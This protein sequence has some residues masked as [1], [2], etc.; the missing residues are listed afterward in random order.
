MILTVVSSALVVILKTKVYS[1]VTYQ[2]QDA[3]ILWR[4]PE[5]CEELALSFNDP[6]GCDEIFAQIEMFQGKCT[7]TATIAA[8]AA[9]TPQDA[10]FAS[11]LDPLPSSSQPNDFSSSSSST[12]SLRPMS[13]DYEPN[14]GGIFGSGDN[15]GLAYPY[16][17]VSQSSS[18]STNSGGGS[19][20][21]SGSG[22]GGSVDGISIGSDGFGRATELP[23]PTPENIGEVERIITDELGSLMHRNTLINTIVQEDYIGKLVVAFDKCEESGATENLYKFFSIFKTLILLNDTKILEV[24]FSQRYTTSVIGAFECK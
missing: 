24:L 2:K 14:E 7:A 5:K 22:G 11:A 18:S 20:S 21:S 17:D 19:S 13:L 23:R 16:G 10:P 3:I 8:A 1:N 6:R 15:S 12:P 4:E 9:A